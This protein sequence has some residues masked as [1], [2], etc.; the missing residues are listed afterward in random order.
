L[1]SVGP[2]TFEVRTSGEPSASVTAIRQAVRELDEGLPLNSIKT[3]IEQ[4]DE[5]LAMERL[6]AR[7]LNLFGLLA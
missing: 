4:A 7:L 3:Q 6:F 5:T 2:V 1:R